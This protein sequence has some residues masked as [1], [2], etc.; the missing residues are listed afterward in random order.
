MQSCREQLI[1]ADHPLDATK[2]MNW[3]VD[4]KIFQCLWS[5][6]FTKFNFFS[7]KAWFGY[8]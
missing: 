2:E 1:D 8:R 7:F 4:H 3:R 5:L 6:V